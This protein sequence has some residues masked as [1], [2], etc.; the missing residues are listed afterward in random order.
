MPGVRR[1]LVIPAEAGFAS[2]S[3]VPGVGAAGTGVGVYVAHDG[4][5]L[6]DS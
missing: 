3:R 5:L 6:T 4:I 1:Q 2:V